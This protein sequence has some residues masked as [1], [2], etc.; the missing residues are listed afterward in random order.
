MY[1]SMWNAV[2]RDQSI[3]AARPSASSVSFCDGAAAKIIRRAGF[4]AWSCR[5]RSATS[6]AAASPSAWRSGVR[7]TAA[8][9]AG[10]QVR[11]QRTVGDG[12]VDDRRP[13]QLD[14]PALAVEVEGGGEPGADAG[15]GHDRAERAAGEPHDR[16]PDVLGFHAVRL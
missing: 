7:H 13:F 6:W 11:R 2:T 10:L 14:R 3:P 4:V 5:I 1:S 12:P 16:Q 8:T 9:A 15:R